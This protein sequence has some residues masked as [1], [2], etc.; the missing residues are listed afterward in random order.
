MKKDKTARFGTKRRKSTSITTREDETE[1][2][3]K[4]LGMYLF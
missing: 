2:W 1:K 3:D 4:R